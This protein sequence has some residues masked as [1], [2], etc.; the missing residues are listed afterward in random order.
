MFKLYFR[1]ILLNL[2]DLL[3][4]KLSDSDRLS[5][6]FECGNVLVL[7]RGFTTGNWPDLNILKGLFIGI[8]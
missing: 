4:S 6:D 7:F 1:Y 5:N 2:P 3:P 8:N